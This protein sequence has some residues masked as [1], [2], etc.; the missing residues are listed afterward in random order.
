[1]NIKASDMTDSVWDFVFL[2][3]DYVPGPVSKETQLSMR[4][5]FK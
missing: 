4:R 3:K 1:M 5:E 2:G